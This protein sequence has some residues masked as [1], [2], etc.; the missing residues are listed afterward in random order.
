[1]MDHL[2]DDSLN[3]SDMK[4]SP[5][6]KLVFDKMRGSSPDEQKKLK[7]EKKQLEQQMAA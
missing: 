1:M 5:R 4:A 6:S 3:S 7:K 2:A